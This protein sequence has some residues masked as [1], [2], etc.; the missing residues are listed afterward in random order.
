MRL[1]QTFSVDSV[2]VSTS[3]YDPVPEGWYNAVI[4]SAEVKTTKAGNGKY[5][6]I[7]YDITGE[8][9]AGRVV[10]GMI[11]VQ[12]PNT[13]AETIGQQQLGE[14]CRAIGKVVLN[15]T[16]ELLGATLSIKVAISAREGYDPRNE[17]KGFKALKG[18]MPSVAVSA[19]AQSSGKAPWDAPF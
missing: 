14:L 2:P 4:H 3:N 16:D 9:H 10:F 6:N 18:G 8:N 1:D 15:D 5:L 17:V 19:P 13:T 11:T 12:N 7:R